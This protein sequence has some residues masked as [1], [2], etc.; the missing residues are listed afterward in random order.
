MAKLRQWARASKAFTLI[1]LLVVIAIIAILIGLLLPAVQKVREAAARIS[2]ANNLKQMSLALHSCNDANLKL[3]PCSNGFPG[4]IGANSQWN[5]PPNNWQTLNPAT[6]GTLQFYILPYMEGGNIYS[7][8]PGVSSESAAVV[9]GYVSPGDPSAPGN[10]MVNVA[11]W[12]SRGATS[13]AANWYV[14]GNADG[15]SANI[16][17]TFQ[18][19]TSNTIVFV[20]RYA[21]C[22]AGVHAWCDDSYPA[23]PGTGGYTTNDT[24]P[25]Y[26]QDAGPAIYGWGNPFNGPNNTTLL[27]LPQFQ[28][29]ASLCDPARTQGPYAGGMMVG[30]GDGSIRLLNSGVSQLTWS[31]AMFPND[32]QPLGSDW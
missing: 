19:G 6:R 26:W 9:K 3:P 10:N 14:F 11:I 20:E 28:P 8:T 18:D 4:A 12:G 21:L 15:G 31:E 23:G 2:D 32:G 25:A 5:N 22:N 29:S 17:R 16:P 27:Q 13:Y 24:A 30:L 7:T 1:E